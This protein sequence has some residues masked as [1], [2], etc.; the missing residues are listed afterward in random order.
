MIKRVKNLYQLK[1]QYEY[2]HSALQGV[3]FSNDWCFIADGCITV[4]AGYAWDGCTPKYDIAGLGVIGT[5]DGR[6]YQGKPITYYASLV[7]DV[8]CQFKDEID[9]SKLQVIQIFNDMLAERNFAARVVYVSAVDWFGPQVFAGD[10][11]L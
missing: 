6:L 1:A 9:I 5:P 2:Q 7:H 11:L 3:E 8:L 10:S 4:A